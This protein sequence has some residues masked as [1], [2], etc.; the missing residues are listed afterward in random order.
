M[1]EPRLRIGELARRTS[2]SAELLRA[3]ERRYGLLR[4]AR[5]PGGYRLYSSDDEL[6]I[7]EM[8]RL[9][10]HGVSAGEAARLV[11]TQGAPE[12]SE[13]GAGSGQEL[14]QALDSFDEAR[15]QVA[16]DALLARLSFET[17]ARDVLVPYL[18]ELGER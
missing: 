4:P 13:N 15:A 3:W 17:M 5:S 6:R 2:V 12:E 11:A 10:E 7:Q 14:R 18:R 16:F 8:K 1:A 9:L